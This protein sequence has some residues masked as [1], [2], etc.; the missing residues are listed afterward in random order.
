V[1]RLEAEIFKACRGFR[2]RIAG[3]FADEEMNVL[4]HDDV[5]EDFEL[6]V[7]AGAFERVEEDVS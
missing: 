4:R 6:V 5:A 1:R 2:E 7:A 3:R